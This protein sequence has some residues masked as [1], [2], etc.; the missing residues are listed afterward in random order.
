MAE[1]HLRVVAQLLDGAPSVFPQIFGGNLVHLV[2]FLH[3]DR[4]DI[5]NIV[6]GIKPAAAA[7]IVYI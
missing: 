4:T 3:A 5:V 7:A 2:N 6:L 1:R